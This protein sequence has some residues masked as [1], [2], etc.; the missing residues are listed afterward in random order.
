MRV[1]KKIISIAFASI[2]CCSLTVRNANAFFPWPGI[3]PTNV[4]SFVSTL[5]SGLKEVMNAKAE[6]DNYVKTI[7]AIG[8][9]VSA[10][11]KFATDLKKAIESIVES[12]N[13]IAMSLERSVEDA[14]T[15][16]NKIKAKMVQTQEANKQ[17]AET[18]SNDVEE[19][20][21]D[22][23]DK[24]EVLEA[25][26]TG[27]EECKTKD[28]EVKDML[29]SAEDQ[30]K[31]SIKDSQETLKALLETLLRDGNL[32]ENARKEIQEKI[33]ALKNQISDLERRANDMINEMR[34]NQEENSA[35]VSEAYEKYE[36]D[37]KDY[38]D[39]KI[40]KE[41][42][43]ARAQEFQNSVGAANS[44]IDEKKLNDMKKETESLINAINDLKEDILDKVANN[45]D[46]SD[47]DEPEKTSAWTIPKT[48]NYAFN[49]HAE[50]SSTYLKGCYAKSGSCSLDIKDGDKSFLISQELTA[51]G[52]AKTGDGKHCQDLKFSMIDDINDNKQN[53]FLDMLRDCMVRAKVEK[54]YFCPT[55]SEKDLEQGKCNPYELEKNFDT[56]KMKEN[57]VYSH[58]IQDYNS[59]NIL[60]ANQMKQYSRTW[61]DTESP[62]ADEKSTLK[63]LTKQFENTD[64]TNSGY[65]MLSML[66]AESLQLWSYIR[67][68]ESINRA[69][70]IVNGYK[71]LNSL[72]LDGRDISAEGENNKIFIEAQEAKPGVFNSG[73]DGNE[74]AKDVSLI[75]NVFLYLCDENNLKGKDISLST[76]EK[77]DE[78]KKKEAE[79]KISDCLKKYAEGASNGTTNDGEKIKVT[80]W[81]IENGQ[82][83]KKEVE[84]QPE[85]AKKRW[86]ENEIKAMTDSQFLT[87]G[88]A[89]MNLYKSSQEYVKVDDPKVNVRKLYEDSQSAEDSR[90]NY[91]L[92]AKSN[93]YA[94]QQLLAIIDA[95]AQAI[96]SEIIGD[97]QKISYDFFPP[98]EQGGAN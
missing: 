92:G 69:K 57:G 31:Q 95:E 30:I 66:D 83:V 55:M 26:E 44:T 8:D 37:I 50:H 21:E 18:V 39:G 73:D 84:D 36:Q 14:D 33:E 71:H 94:T 46:Y 70:K 27:R 77:A 86:R 4:G 74:N 35:K 82:K 24:D 53:D 96:Q 32:D 78:T 68:M 67:R 16:L 63:K 79:Q 62:D 59:A 65:T 13:K 1:G 17:V 88:L 34:K 52:P 23:A 87:F 75:S 3:S 76:K 25:L 11:A 60:N 47:E 91:G 97:L 9:Q 20:I 61:L 90:N 29:D 40:T 10:V 80:A 48:V 7:N 93:Y 38:Y 64:S 98:K 54:E 72:Y 5:S 15:I 58:I 2:L 22:S 28:K 41:E 6:I 45:K 12:V 42:L 51:R 43:D 49:F 81:T 56:K 19:L 85:I 89:T